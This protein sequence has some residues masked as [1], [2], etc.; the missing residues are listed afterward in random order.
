MNVLENL[1]RAEEKGVKKGIE[2]VVH[3]LWIQKEIMGI[4]EK[5]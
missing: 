2:K 3:N 1:L 5:I 4:D